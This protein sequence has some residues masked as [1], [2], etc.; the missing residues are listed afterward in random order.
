MKVKIGLIYFL[1]PTILFAKINEANRY[2]LLLKAAKE[3][4]SSAVIV[5]K[6]GKTVFTYYSVPKN[7]LVQAMSVTKSIVALAFAQLL[8]EGKMKS[9]DTKV[10][11]YYPCW[12]QGKKQTITI[13]E[14]L[15]HTS[16]LENV[17]NAEVEIYPSRN[18]VQL[19]LCAEL[20]NDPGTH[21]SYNNKAVNLLPGIVQ[22]VTGEPLDAFLKNGL[23]KEMG[24]TDFKWDHDSSGNPIGMAGF[25]VR[26]IDLAKLGELVLDKGRWNG[27]QLISANWIDSLTAQGQPFDSSCGLLWWRTPNHTSYI[28]DAA[29]IKKLRDAGAGKSFI[30]K[31]EEI[32]GT[33]NSETDYIA[34]L[35]HEFGENFPLVINDAIGKLGIAL[36]RK[37]SGKIVG[38]EGDGYLGQYV[39]VYP[40]QHMVAVRM[41]EGSDTYNGRTD[42][43]YD[44]P[45]MVYGLIS[46][47]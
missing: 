21:F 47:K 11:E 42:G 30:S 43:F 33:Y 22:K 36:A 39:V 15:N 9:L 1:L 2:Q 6:D 14:I 25:D 3:S 16:G 24:I 19:A 10:C 17:P 13:R 44:F 29:Q 7:T 31:V 37:K 28:V 46:G 34:A 41:V 4:H 20:S 23:F 18:F 26:P 35:T 40:K 12:R 5:M 27:K 32:K 38:Y 45:Q 8:S